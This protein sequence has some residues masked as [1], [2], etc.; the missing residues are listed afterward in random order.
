LNIAWCRRPDH[1][2]VVVSLARSRGFVRA[3]RRRC[4]LTKRRWFGRRTCSRAFPRRL[5]GRRRLGASRFERTS[6]FG[7]ANRLEGW[8]RFEGG[9]CRRRRR[10]VV[11][12]THFVRRWGTGRAGSGTESWAGA[13]AIRGIFAAFAPAAAAAAATPPAAFAALAGRSLRVVA[14]GLL[15]ARR[16]ISTR[17]LIWTRR[18]ICP[19]GHIAAGRLIRPE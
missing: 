6:R 5:I 4:G 18:L 14:A 16:L 1:V 15:R 9:R 13:G 10:T 11:A 12:G 17:C 2:F 8:R 3:G 7:G 19:R